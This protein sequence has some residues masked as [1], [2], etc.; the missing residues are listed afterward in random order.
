MRRLWLFRSS[1]EVAGSSMIALL[2]AI[3]AAAMSST[4]AAATLAFAVFNWP[5]SRLFLG[6]AGAYTLGFVLSWF[7]IAILLNAPEASPWAILLA[8]FWPLADMVFAVARRLGQRRSTFRADK[9]HGHHVVLRSLEILGLG[10]KRGAVSNPLATLIL[11]PNNRTQESEADVVGQ[12]LMAKAG[13][14]P[15]Q[16]VSL[17]QNMIEANTARAPEWMSTHPANASRIRLSLS[18]LFGGS[19]LHDQAILARPD[20]APQSVQTG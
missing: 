13:F 12:Q 1:R 20:R 2:E 16:A 14:N 6:D 5:K 7:G 11:L 8:V 4:L 18:G 10:K 9:M 15:D 19:I 17:W 3:S